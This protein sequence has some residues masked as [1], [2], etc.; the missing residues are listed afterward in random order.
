MGLAHQVMSPLVAE[1]L[2]ADAP[3][4]LD[5]L[6]ELE[7]LHA[8]AVSK[9]V[10]PTALSR[11]SRRPRPSEGILLMA[12]LPFLSFSRPPYVADNHLR[13]GWHYRGKVSI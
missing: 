6:D 4:G 10:T 9:A 2:A 5:G 8:E 11:A 7:L 12:P 3:P 13:H 1:P